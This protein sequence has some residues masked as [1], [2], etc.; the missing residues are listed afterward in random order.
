M[1]RAYEMLSVPAV[2]VKE[3]LS[4]LSSVR[5]SVRSS[6]RSV[7]A[8]SSSV[9]TVRPVRQSVSPS[10]RP[11]VRPSVCPSTRRLGIDRKQTQGQFYTTARRQKKI[12]FQFVLTSSNRPS[13]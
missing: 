6:I 9:R 12:S 3:R 1:Q 2:F 10:V 11:S 5:P 8:S 13:S 4:G 7:R